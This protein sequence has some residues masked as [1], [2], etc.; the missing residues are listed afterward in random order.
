MAQ[1]DLQRV[2]LRRTGPQAET[3]SVAASRIEKTPDVDLLDRSSPSTLLVEG[4]AHTIR[5][6]VGELPGWSAFPMT[7]YGHPETRRRVLKPADD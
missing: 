5:Q 4:S 7:T 3:S 2:V 6:I 1:D